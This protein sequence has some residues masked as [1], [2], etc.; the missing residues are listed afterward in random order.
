MHWLLFNNVF[1]NIHEPKNVNHDHNSQKK[2]CLIFLSN[3][4]NSHPNIHTMV[5]SFL[6]DFSHE[7]IEVGNQLINGNSYKNKTVQLIQ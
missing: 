4:L 7:E 6:F 2:T 5:F 1:I 3:G